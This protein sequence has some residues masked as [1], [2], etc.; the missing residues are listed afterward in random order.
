MRMESFRGGRIITRTFNNHGEAGNKPD[1]PTVKVEQ[2]ENL[3]TFLPNGKID[4]GKSGLNNV[5]PSIDTNGHNPTR[6]AMLIPLYRKP[7]TPVFKAPFGGGRPGGGGTS[8][9]ALQ[10]AK[11]K[12]RRQGK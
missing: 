11:R 9:E 12:L 8:K 7:L 6:G 4:L 10:R 3:T 2:I 5:E 1:V